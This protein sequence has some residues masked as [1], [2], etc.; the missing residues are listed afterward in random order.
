MI[1]KKNIKS[2]NLFKKY[3]EIALSHSNFFNDSLSIF[4]NHNN[5][6]ENR[7]CQSVLS[8][9]YKTQIDDIIIEDDWEKIGNTFILTR[10]RE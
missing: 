9:L 4:P 1:I 2:I 5:F 10:I 6:I 8:L 3:W 7:H